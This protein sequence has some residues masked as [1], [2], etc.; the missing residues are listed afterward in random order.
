[1]EDAN[2]TNLASADF[3]NP[4]DVQQSDRGGIERRRKTSLGKGFGGIIEFDFGSIHAA[5]RSVM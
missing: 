1:M 5:T 2:T 3:L 4:P